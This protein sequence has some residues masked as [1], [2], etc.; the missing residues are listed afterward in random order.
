MLA[1]RPACIRLRGVRQ[2]N[3]KSIDL[4]LPLHQLVVIAGLSGSGKSSLAFETLFAEGQRRY[5]ETFSPY[6]R[7]FLDRM[8]KPQA[9]SIEGIPPAIA[10]EQRN[11]VKSTRSTVGAM[12]EL[13]EYAKLFWPHLAQLHCRRCG[14]PV[15]KDSPQKIW[16]AVRSLAPDSEAL[17]TFDLALSGKFS[18]EES[19]AL[20]SRQGYQR[21]FFNGEVIPLDQ[22]S[23]RLKSSVATCVTVLQD[24]VRLSAQNRARFVEACE[25]AYHFGKGKLAVR[26]LL[27]DSS[28]APFSN[29]MHCAQCDLEY[30]EPTAALF[31][32]NHP[33]GACAACRGFGRVIAI[34][35]DAAIP[36]RSK[37]L[38][39][40]AVKPWQ[41]P[42]NAECQEELLKFARL[43]KVPVDVPFR[44]LPQK[45]RDWVIEGD[46][47]Y[48]KDKAHT[49][50]RA[51]YGVKGYFRWL[52]SRAYK[53]HV[54]VQLSRYR[55]YQTCPNCHGTRF[56]P[57]ALLYRIDGL[58]LADFYRLPVRQALRFVDS[59]M[60]KGPPPKVS[61]PMTVALSEVRSRLAYLDEVG[62]NYLTLDRLTRSLSGGE[63]ERVNL[64][65]C[66]GSRLVNT[67]FVLDEPS[68][69][70]HPRD[71]ARLVRIV[72]QLR[73][74]GNTVVVVEHEASVMRAADQIIELGPGRGGPAA[75]WCFKGLSRKSCT[76]QNP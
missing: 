66:L 11:T 7:Q 31:S 56:G 2:N 38:A 20:I 6:A 46:A 73:D 69:G 10:I 16:A 14:E 21:L 19:L 49:W 18:L 55:I 61:D 8:D 22:A 35:Y 13:T 70:L 34:D 33:I 44:D 28:A 40:G 63:T 71:T 65:A 27:P 39:G 5:I 68:V 76:T 67:L 25:Q 60:A 58:T 41:T 24:R 12:T 30:A 52:E 51:W 50:P 23:A 42:A 32:F 26:S 15:Q 48:N 37:T 62:L 43:R 59:L 75:K 72:R 9:D 47:N 53:M 29:R 1:H 54:R 45:W 64:T 17:V 57:D 74:T 3:L 36:D 4:D